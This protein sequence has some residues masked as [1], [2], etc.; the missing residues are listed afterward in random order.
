MAS[1]TIYIF[2]PEEAVDVW[3]PVSAELVSPGV[4]RLVSPPEPGATRL[5]LGDLVRCE[6]RRLE[7]GDHL[8]AVE[9]VGAGV[10]TAAGME[11]MVQRELDLV[12][13]A[14][15][16]AELAKLLVAPV[17]M[18]LGWDYGETRDSSRDRLDCWQVGQSPDG[19]TLLVYCEQGFG[20][21][22]SWGF[23]GRTDDSLG[24]DSQWH[25][26]LEHAAIVAD[27]LDAPPD[28]EVP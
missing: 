19:N 8:V 26:G 4:Y 18:N 5:R 25:I 24:M 7:D 16:R 9:R 2:L 6:Q 12:S 23:V 10:R 21:S 3:C 15:R 17:R 22:D 28:Y 13:D 11:R 1:T 14:H 27:L 20:P